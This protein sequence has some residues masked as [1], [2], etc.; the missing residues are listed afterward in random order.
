MPF[1]SGHKLSFDNNGTGLRLHHLPPPIVHLLSLC[2]GTR[3]SFE[4]ASIMGA[5][6]GSPMEGQDSLVGWL[7]AMNRFS[8][9]G[10]LACRSAN[11]VAHTVRAGA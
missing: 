11:P 2:D 4:I 9:D 10:L 7:A 8:E 5:E 1:A 3:P 6:F